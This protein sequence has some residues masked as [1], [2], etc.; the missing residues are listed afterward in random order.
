MKD[1][2]RREKLL[3][4]VGY[5]NEALR[6]AGGISAKQRRFIEVAANYGKELEPD[7]WLAGGGSQ[8]KNP[9]AKN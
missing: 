7:G 9:K 1:K 8:V 2:K 6:L 4:I 5:H 3:E